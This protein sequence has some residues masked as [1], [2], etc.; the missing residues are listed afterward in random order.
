[1]SVRANWFSGTHTPV[2]EALDPF[3]DMTASKSP[4]AL[5]VD[6][7]LEEITARLARLMKG[8][9]R[10]AEMGITCPLKESG[11]CSCSACPVSQL[12]HPEESKAALCR[13]GQEQERLVMM[14]LAKTHGLVADDGGR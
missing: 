11:E 7:P 6:S 10:L 4:I 1:M 8:E 2:D 14:S 9:G 3:A 5:S 12:S 13:L